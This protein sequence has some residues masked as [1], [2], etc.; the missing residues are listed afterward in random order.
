MDPQ[1][2]RTPG[3]CALYYIYI[4]CLFE[5]PVGLE[6]KLGGHTRV[7]SQFCA[8]GHWV[9]FSIALRPE[10]ALH[11]YRIFDSKTSPFIYSKKDNLR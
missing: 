1:Q 6:Y 9:L 4:L 10:C 11:A 7:L 8:F 5:A 3:L 2:F